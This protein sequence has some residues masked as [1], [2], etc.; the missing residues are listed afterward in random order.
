MNEQY[1]APL[2]K[3]Q[4]EYKNNV[5][6]FNIAEGAVRAGKTVLQIQLFAM[7][8]ESTE[9]EYH[10]ISGFSIASAKLIIGESNGYGLI[11]I[12]QGRCK[13]SMYR[14]KDCLI[15]DTYTNGRKVCVISGS[16]TDKDQNNIVGMSFG[17]WIAT[18]IDRHN[19]S[20]IR[21]A[22]NRLYASKDMRVFWDFNPTSPSHFIYKNYVD[23]WRKNNP[24]EVNYKQ[25]TLFDNLSL[26]DKQIQKVLMQYSRG[27]VWFKRD[28]LGQRLNLEGSIYPN[29]DH[30]YHVRDLVNVRKNISRYYI[31]IDWGYT[32][33]ATS[34]IL[35]GI[36]PQQEVIVID[37][38][39]NATPKRSSQ[40]NLN[41]VSEFIQKH[42]M[43]YPT[44]YCDSADVGMMRDLSK[45]FPSRVANYKK[46]KIN[47]RIIVTDKLMVLNKLIIS[48]HCEH[49]I[50][51]FDNAMFDKKS[52]N[53]RLDN[54]S[55]NVDSLDAFEYSITDLIYQILDR[56]II[57]DYQ[58][59]RKQP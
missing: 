25:F 14:N 38:Y 53:I 39:Y 22:L 40:D 4:L 21:E 29:F 17:G 18:E 42:I 20:F 36:T 28:I 32:G 35:V 16:G 3:N 43:Y 27:S 47:D 15:I 51:G 5:K 44:I 2:S 54:G 34:A 12:Y 57:E 13:Y 55:Y 59:Y 48:N 30:R 26:T 41:E 56:G 1:L 52:N 11:H 49:L 50:S 23:K 37:E 24:S 58:D 7:F 31:G 10:L 19:E 6:T 45:R 9:D 46:P 8:L 33:S